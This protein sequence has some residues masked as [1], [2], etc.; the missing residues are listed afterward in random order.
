LRAYPSLIKLGRSIP[1]QRNA[2]LSRWLAENV[3]AFGQALETV[4]AK[5]G[6]TLLHENLLFAQVRD[7]SLRVQLERELKE[8]LVVLS[9]HYIAFP[10][11]SRPSVEKVLKK[12]GFVVKTVKP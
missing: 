3:P 8:N 4:N 11:E 5:W 9:D 1:A 7:L 2:P 6:K 12:T 10:Q